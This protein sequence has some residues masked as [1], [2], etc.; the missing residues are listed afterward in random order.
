[1]SLLV[2]VAKKTFILHKRKY[3]SS[4]FNQFKTLEDFFCLHI[5]KCEQNY[6]PIHPPKK[7]NYTFFFITKKIE[8]SINSMYVLVFIS[9]ECWSTYG[10]TTDIPVVAMYACFHIWDRDLFFFLLSLSLSGKLSRRIYFLTGCH[11]QEGIKSAFPF[12]YLD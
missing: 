11:S 2:S 1:M 3:Y 9:Q 4:E 5:L 10:C 12:I 6:L 7:I 8:V